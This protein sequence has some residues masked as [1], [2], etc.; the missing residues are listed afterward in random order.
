MEEDALIAAAQA[1]IREVFQNDYSG[2][3]YF[4]SLRVFKTAE[5]I[6]QQ[7]AADRTVVQLAALLHDVDD[8]KLSPQTHAHK[9]RATAF[10]RAQGVCVRRIEAIC[11]IIGEVSYSGTDSVVPE[12]IEGKCVQDADR[13]DAI[14][15]IGIARAFAYGGSHGRAIHDPEIKPRLQMSGEQYQRHI[16]SS[17]NHFYEKLFNLAERMNTRSARQIAEHR[18]QFMREY[19][20]EFLDEWEGLL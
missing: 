9:D 2:H 13:L 1:Y 14:G 6:A 17:V 4:H 19:L 12:T 18:E 16:S 7:E 5:R 3:D 15:A 8:R 10:L 11:T 20:R